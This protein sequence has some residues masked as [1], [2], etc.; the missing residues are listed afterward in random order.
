MGLAP[1]G[2]GH[3]QAREKQKYCPHIN[4]E[5][6][7]PGGW[8]ARHHRKAWHGHA[9]LSLANAKHTRSGAKFCPSTVSQNMV[10]HPWQ[11]VM[12]NVLQAYCT[13]TRCFFSIPTRT[14]WIA[15]P[16]LTQQNIFSPKEP[17]PAVHHAPAW[18]KI[19]NGIFEKAAS[20]HLTEKGC[21]SS[22]LF[23]PTAAV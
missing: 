13:C 3:R 16:R 9:N 10:L 22:P 21:G 20:F 6:G 4:I 19:S 15:M 1:H 8:R 11:R 2:G 5:H 12:P 17:Q 23:P 14:L 18:L 7:G